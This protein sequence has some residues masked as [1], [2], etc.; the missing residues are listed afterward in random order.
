MLGPLFREEF[1]ELE[2]LYEEAKREQWNAATDIDW[3]Q[4][5]KF[6]PKLPS[7]LARGHRAFHV[8]MIYEGEAMAITTQPAVHYA[9]DREARAFTATLLVDEV[10][11]AEVF[12]RY[13]RLLGEP[14]DLEGVFEPYIELQA[15]AK[16]YLEFLVYSGIVAEGLAVEIVDFNSESCPLLQKILEKV[17]RDEDRH[18]RFGYLY[19]DIL[20]ARASEEERSAV[21]QMVD[22]AVQTWQDAMKL[23]TAKMPTM[24]DTYN[25]RLGRQWQREFPRAVRKLEQRISKWGIRLPEDL[26]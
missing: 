15:N 18:H 6:D 24:P 16:S 2:E 10:R 23:V 22:N 12:D 26:A 4:E 19:F 8:A 25:L 1:K 7:V 5:I 14:Y 21:Q 13:L 17:G 11:H 9:P 20:M 3:S